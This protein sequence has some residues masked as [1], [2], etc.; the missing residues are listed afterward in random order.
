[1]TS[2]LRSENTTKNRRRFGSESYGSLAIPLYV[3]KMKSIGRSESEMLLIISY[4]LG[5]CSQS[6]PLE[7]ARGDNVGSIK[8]FQMV[9]QP[10]NPFIKNLFIGGVFGIQ[11]SLTTVVISDAGSQHW[12]L[13]Q[14]RSGSDSIVF[15]LSGSWK[16]VHFYCHTNKDCKRTLCRLE[17]SRPR[18]GENCWKERK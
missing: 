16:N 3:S 14:F 12:D 7:W 8:R 10:L 5:R 6:R 17:G 4:L 11:D 1:M 18:K 15:G 13:S 2:R 9:W